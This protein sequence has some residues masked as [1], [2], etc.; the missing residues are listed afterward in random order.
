M[1]KNTPAANAR[2]PPR[3]GRAWPASSTS[4]IAESSAA[5]GHSSA[6]ARFA[7]PIAA[8]DHP[9]A[10][11]SDVIDKASSGLCRATARKVP[12]PHSRQ[13]TLPLP[14]ETTAAPSATPSI[15]VCSDSP[16]ASPPQLNVC[17]PP[18]LVAD[19]AEHA[20]P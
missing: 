18:S 9:P 4:P 13:E 11:I 5:T 7:R 16:R 19:P 12:N 1:H 10:A 17:G 6:K 15:S 20:G 2:H 14:S 3:I 8:R